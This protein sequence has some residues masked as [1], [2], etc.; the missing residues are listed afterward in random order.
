MANKKATIDVTLA[1]A[2]ERN[3]TRERSDGGNTVLRNKDF[4]PEFRVEGMHY[5]A[6]IEKARE[7]GVITIETC[8]LTKKRAI[9]TIPLLTGLIPT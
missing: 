3:G 2:R 9:D 1:R 8:T 6:D 4:H 5:F 7:L